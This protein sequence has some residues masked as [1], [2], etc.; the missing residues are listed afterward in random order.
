MDGTYWD[1]VTCAGIFV[2]NS[3]Q[4]SLMCNVYSA[5]DMFHLKHTLNVLIM[6]VQVVN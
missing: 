5:E 1:G 4:V 2:Y 6:F 3:C